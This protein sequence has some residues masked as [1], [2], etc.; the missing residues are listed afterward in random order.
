MDNV[1]ARPPQKFEDFARESK[2]ENEVWLV[3]RGGVI[4]DSDHWNQ[5]HSY[6][7]QQHTSVK[8]F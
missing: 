7:L 4:S 6:R 2:Q 3:R 8:L 1:S 5:K